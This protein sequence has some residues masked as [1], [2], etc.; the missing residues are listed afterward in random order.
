MKI[1]GFSKW[2]FLKVFRV[3]QALNN[4]DQ[5]IILIKNPKTNKYHLPR[6]IWENGLLSDF[7]DSFAQIYLY[8]VYSREDDRCGKVLKIVPTE[9]IKI[10]LNFIK[11]YKKRV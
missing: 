2:K 1:Y 4:E 10:Y 7:F 3:C 5:V 8:Q 11:M 9:N 6:P